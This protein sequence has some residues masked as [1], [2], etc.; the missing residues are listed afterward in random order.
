ML[1]DFLTF[2]KIAITG[3]KQDYQS[4]MLYANALC[5]LYLRQQN[6]HYGDSF[7]LCA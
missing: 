5:K 2:A 6:K 4:N 3:Q 1:A 7:I